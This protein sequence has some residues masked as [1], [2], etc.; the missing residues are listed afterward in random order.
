MSDLLNQLEIYINAQKGVGFNAFV[1]SAGMIVSAVLLHLNGT[2]QL[3]QGLRNG[4]FV[5]G[6]VLIAMGIGL[7]I[8]QENIK[9]ERQALYQQD[10][11]EFKKVEIE[12]MTKVKNNYPK[13]QAIM[14]GLVVISLITF[15]LVKSPLWQGIS[16]SFTV[17]FVGNI[18]MEAFSYLSI[19]SYF[20]SLTN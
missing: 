2:S 5:I 15:L 4:T 10:E 17:F 18:I 8:S 1:F 11:V 3:A 12:R 16:L 20:Q 19:I 9:K 7:R 13:A 6:I 14:A